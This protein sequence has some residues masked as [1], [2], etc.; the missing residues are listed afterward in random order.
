M[1]NKLPKKVFDEIYT[2]V[3]RLC[4]DLLVRDSLGKVLLTKRSVG[5]NNNWHFPGGTLQF[6][7]S[8]DSCAKRVAKE[9][10]SI[11]ITPKN[12]VG[13]IEYPFEKFDKGFGQPITLVLDCSPNSL[14][15]VL[16]WQ[17]TEW[18]FFSKKEVPKDTIPV[19][20]E[21]LKNLK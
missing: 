11:E 5:W 14:D 21:F 1:V 17:A 9:E 12:F 7:E 15:I 3:P 8:L 18:K 20:K 19:V 2:K 13:I 4:V 6:G 10:L 16:D